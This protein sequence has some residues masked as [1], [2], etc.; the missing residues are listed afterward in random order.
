MYEATA[1]RPAGDRR[2]DSVNRRRERAGFLHNRSELFDD[3]QELHSTA[4]EAL[5][6]IVGRSA[7]LDQ[8]RLDLFRN[9]LDANTFV[10]LYTCIFELFGVV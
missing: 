10:C 2:P 1:D 5:L 3:Q 6:Q 8:I 7:F 9:R 4:R